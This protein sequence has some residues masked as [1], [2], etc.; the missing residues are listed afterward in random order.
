M[1]ISIFGA[2][3]NI[4]RRILDEAIRQHHEVRIIVRPNAKTDHIPA[5]VEIVHGDI[6]NREDVQR[7]SEGQDVVI[8]AYG[9]GYV[10]VSPLID[11]TNS[12]I[13]G[14]KATQNPPRLMSVGGAGS[15]LV[16]SDTVLLNSEGFPKE[17]RP[18]SQVHLDAL[19]IYQAS[20]GINWTN[21]SPSALIEAGERTGSYRLHETHLISD[22]EGNSRISME[23]FA[24]A[25]IQEVDKQEFINKRF[26]VGY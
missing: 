9:P 22:E 20:E 1:K 14:I 23:D 19:E 24:V 7:H 21:V 8:S 4:G 16:G 2:T 15:L 26:T 3:G 5:G 12:L 10:E 6:F 25:I 18:I 13:E 17:W 11:A